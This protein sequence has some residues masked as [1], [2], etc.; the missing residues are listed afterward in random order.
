MEVRTHPAHERGG[1]CVVHKQWWHPFA[2]EK[3]TFDGSWRLFCS[4]DLVCMWNGPLV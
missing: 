3:G 2:V 4:G 1:G